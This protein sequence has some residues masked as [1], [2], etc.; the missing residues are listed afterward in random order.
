MEPSSF[1]HHRQ[2]GQHGGHHEQQQR[3][4]GRHHRRQAAHV[5]VVARLHAGGGRRGDAQALARLLR[6]P[7]LVHA[8]HV[9]TDGL[10]ALRH[11]AVDPHA[12]LRRLAA[13]RVAGEALRDLDGQRQLAAA[14]ARVHVLVVRHGSMF[15]EVARAGQVQRVV[16]AQPGLVAVHHRVA[17]VFHVQAD[18]EADDEHQQQRA[19]QRQRGAHRVALQLQRFAPH[20]AQHAL[21]AEATVGDGAAGWAAASSMAGASA[22]APAPASIR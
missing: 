19:G 8:Q 16:L 7:A 6:Q 10:G 4:H 21:R 5:G 11:G 18:A 22:L 20:I 13:L 9:A 1:S 12:D 15:D 2:R 14:H 3:N 17:Q